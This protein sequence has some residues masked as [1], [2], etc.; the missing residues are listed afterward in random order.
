MH[1]EETKKKIGDAN[2]RPVSF[3]CDSCG[4]WSITKPS[5]Y[6]KKRRHFCDQKCYSA[7]RREKMSNH[8]AGTV[9]VKNARR[10]ISTST[11]IQNSWK[12]TKVKENEL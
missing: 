8:Y 6:K 12:T 1:S 3:I 10:L 11:K 7:F 9:T 4:K 5:A 2:R